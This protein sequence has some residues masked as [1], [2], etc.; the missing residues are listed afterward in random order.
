MQGIL[1]LCSKEAD[2]PIL[3]IGEHICLEH[4]KQA[5]IRSLGQET[6]RNSF[7]LGLLINFSTP[8]DSVEY[9]E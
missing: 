8:K 7:L 4:E 2:K 1:P 5:V 9:F 3:I 6:A